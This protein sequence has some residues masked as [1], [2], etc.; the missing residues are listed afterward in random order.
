MSRADAIERFAREARARGV[1]IEAREFPEGTRTAVDAARAIGCEVSQIVKS[2]VFMAGDEPFLALTSGSKRADT[3]RL[4]RLMGGRPV[5]QA[6]AN[7]AREATGFAIGGTPPFG[8][9]EPL[10]VLC[11][12]D[13]LEHE[14]VWA[15]AGTPSSV[16]PI[17]P[18]DLLRASGARSADFKERPEPGS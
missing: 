11:D 2:L 3:Q 12:P 9:P 5:R 6:T 13:L 4:S 7:E 1:D 8:H 10:P 17:S 16:F 18:Q 14:V 15:A